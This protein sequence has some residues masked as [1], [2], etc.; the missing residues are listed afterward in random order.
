ME[1]FTLGRETG[2]QNYTTLRSGVDMNGMKTAP[3]I[4]LPDYHPDDERE[5]ENDREYLMQMYPAK[6]RIVMAMIEKE[7][8]KLEYDGSPMYMRYPDKETLLLYAAEITGRICGGAEDEEL[9]QL[10]QVLFV[11]ECYNRR[12]KH[13]RRRKFY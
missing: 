13:R 5:Y 12:N 8:D 10:I 6:A 7:C 11:N 9:N 3:R 1:N 4:L 2:T